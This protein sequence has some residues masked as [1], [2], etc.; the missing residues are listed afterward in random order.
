MVSYPEVLVILTVL[1]H[2]KN[3]PKINNMVR[4]WNQR[5]IRKEFKLGERSAG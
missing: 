5:G 4:L 1:R 3:G 2:I